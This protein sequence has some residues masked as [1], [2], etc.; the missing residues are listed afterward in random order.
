MHI[1]WRLSVYFLAHFVLAVVV[2]MLAG[3]RV[4][5]LSRRVWRIEYEKDTGFDF[6][7]SIIRTTQRTENPE[8]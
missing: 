4:H 1:V 5:A 6:A 8:S 7:M 3:K 2:M